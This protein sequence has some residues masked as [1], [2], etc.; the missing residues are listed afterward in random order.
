MSQPNS[1]PSSAQNLLD[2]LIDVRQ[3]VEQRGLAISDLLRDSGLFSAFM[4]DLH[5]DMNKEVTIISLLINKGL[6]TCLHS[7]NANDRVRESGQIKL[8]LDD[9]GLKAEDAQAYRDVLLAFCNGEKTLSGVGSR[10]PS[11]QPAAAPPSSN[12][13]DDLFSK[14]AL[15]YAK[16]KYSEAFN[17]FS[18]AAVQGHEIHTDIEGR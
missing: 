2:A 12:V 4:L 11:P 7:A 15:S 5:P 13:A 16:G 9:F 17:W 3:T 14:G 8:W 18:Q 1:S 6:L 10:A